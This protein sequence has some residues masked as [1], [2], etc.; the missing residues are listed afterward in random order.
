M[1]G[2]WPVRGHLLFLA[3]H[4]IICYGIGVLLFIYAYVCMYMDLELQWSEGS[5][6]FLP[7]SNEDL[8][9]SSPDGID[10]SCPA[11]GVHCSQVHADSHYQSGS[12]HSVCAS[13]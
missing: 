1:H 7:C 5:S 8:R 13:E 6:G 12:L 3:L 11:R 4:N 9:S 10:R 2:K